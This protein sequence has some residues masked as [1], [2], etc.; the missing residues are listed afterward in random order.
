M[1]SRRLWTLVVASLTDSLL[2][3][4]LTI[5]DTRSA[6]QQTSAS[7]V[8]CTSRA[9]WLLLW[10]LISCPCTL[11]FITNWR[12][13]AGGIKAK[14]LWLSI[15]LA[16]GELPAAMAITERPDG[17]CRPFE[18]EA[19]PHLKKKNNFSDYLHIKGN[20][21]TDATIVLILKMCLGVLSAI[22][23]ASLWIVSRCLVR[24][25]QQSL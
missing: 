9:R 20:F 12:P 1:Y 8:T 6:G 25:G 2:L 10:R 7:P 16:V 18:K 19:V 13:G 21:T 11:S 15:M 23:Y 4:T 17:I 24:R 3:P 5:T 22:E 14:R